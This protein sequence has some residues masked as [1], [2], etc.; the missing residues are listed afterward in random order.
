MNVSLIV[1]VFCILL[2]IVLAFAAAIPSGWVHL[3]LVVGVVLLA[4]AI[5]ESKSR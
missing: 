1:A 3:P 4:K 5:L 2:W